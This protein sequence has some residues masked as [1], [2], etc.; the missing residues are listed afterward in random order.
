MQGTSWAPGPCGRGGTGVWGKY[1]IVH[2]S[3]HL[4]RPCAQRYWHGCIALVDEK[5]PHSLPCCHMLAL[6]PTY[7]SS[8]FDVSL[9]HRPAFHSPDSPFVNT[10]LP[11]QHNTA[12]PGGLHEWHMHPHF[13]INPAL[14]GC[15]SMP[16]PIHTYP[17]SCSPAS[18]ALGPPNILPHA[19]YQ[20]QVGRG[21]GGE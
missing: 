10:G 19:P 17:C 16:S 9:P 7:H 20:Q 18:Y 2:M 21:R 3:S 14:N 6:E 11:V 12:L 8:P 4:R 1:M 5:T 15:L 13:A